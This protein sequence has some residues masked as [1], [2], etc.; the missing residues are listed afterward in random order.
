MIKK[1]FSK[2]L[3]YCG[4]ELKLINKQVAHTDDMTLFTNSTDPFGATLSKMPFL[5]LSWGVG[6][7][8]SN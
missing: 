7:F 4:Y 1:T 3:K 2:I 5:I 8:F 6:K